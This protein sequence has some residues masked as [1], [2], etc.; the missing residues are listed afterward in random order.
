[1][2]FDDRHGNDDEFDKQDRKYPDDN[3]DFI[4]DH[5]KYPPDDDFDRQD[6]RGGDDSGEYPDKGF[7]DD[8]FKFFGFQLI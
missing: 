8:F 1:M 5:E 7:D 2:S 4:D 6:S 3:D